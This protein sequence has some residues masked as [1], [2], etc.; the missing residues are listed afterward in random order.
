MSNI[1]VV[2]HNRI[3]EKGMTIK[4]VAE[5][6]DLTP[7]ALSAMLAG[8]QK[9]PAIAFINLCFILELTPDNFTN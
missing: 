7:Q 1:P 4:S 9:I 5:R 2:I 3:Y 6:A 8:R